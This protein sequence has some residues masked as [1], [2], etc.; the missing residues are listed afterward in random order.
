MTDTKVDIAEL[1]EL[2]TPYQEKCNFKF[3][4]DNDFLKFNNTFYFFLN[5]IRSIDSDDITITIRAEG[6]VIYLYKKTDMVHT[7]IF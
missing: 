5:K 6:Y 7:T 2:L 4:D 1:K 3:S